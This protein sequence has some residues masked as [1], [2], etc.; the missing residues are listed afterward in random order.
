MKIDVNENVDF[1]QL[2]Q[3]GMRDWNG[4]MP[5]RM[6]DDSLEEQFWQDVITRKAPNPTSDPHIQPL[7]Q[8]LIS[9]VQHEDS[10]LEIG[11]GWGNYTFPLLEY[12]KD[13]TAVDSSK[14]IIHFIQMIKEKNGYKDLH[15]LNKKWEEWSSSQT[16]DVVFGINCFYRMYDIQRALKTIHTTANRLA[17]VGMTTGPMRPHYIELQQTYGVKLKSPRRDYIHLVNLLYELGIYA[18]CEVVELEKTF[19]YTTYEELIKANSI[20]LRNEPQ[21]TKL[22]EKVISQYCTLH[23]GKYHYTHKFHGVLVTWTPNGTL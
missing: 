4:N 8:K 2:W 13:I 17:I 1:V 23:N 22:V 18:N 9:Y 10:V 15:L 14:H 5:E 19:V 12:V 11:P 16:Y 21:D 20:K 6:V 7:L 3:E